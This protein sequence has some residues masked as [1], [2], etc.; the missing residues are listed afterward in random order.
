MKKEN[1][2]M[3]NLRLTSVEIIEKLYCTGEFVSYKEAA[4]QFFNLAKKKHQKTGFDLHNFDKFYNN[5]RKFK[6]RSQ[7]DSA[8]EY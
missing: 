6:S 5:Y 4:R 7:E 2:V 8:E 3:Y 1:P